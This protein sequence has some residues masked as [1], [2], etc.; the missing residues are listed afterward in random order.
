[1]RVSLLPLFP[2]AFGEYKNE[3]N[4]SHK[5]LYD[6][7]E[8]IRNEHG[9]GR[10]VSNI[11]G[12]QSNNLDIKYLK[13]GIGEFV[14]SSMVDYLNAFQFTGKV[15]ITI[16]NFWLNVNKLYQF[17]M[18]HH[19]IGDDIDFACVYYLKVPK[20]AGPLRIDDP[21]H[22]SKFAVKFFRDICKHHNMTPYLDYH[23]REKHLAIFPAY[24]M[25]SVMPSRRESDEERWSMAFNIK[26]ELDLDNETR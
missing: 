19:H 16:I 2:T 1:M 6:A 4:N 14:E 25:H 9:D 15:K 7:V 12:W 21:A 20:D 11:G 3:D 5:R 22:H 10:Q 17:N 26:V 18:T 8:D 24:A 13:E 23:A